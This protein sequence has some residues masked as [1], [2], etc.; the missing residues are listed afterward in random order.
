MIAKIVKGQGFRGV[1]N[2][3][4]D[5]AKGTQLIVA[6]GLRLKDV[7][8]VINSFNRQ[9]E[10]NKRITK[11]VY[12]ISLDFSANDKAK[13]TN[14]LMVRIAQSYM[15]KMGIKDTQYL[16]ARHFDKEHP[17][18]HLII[19]RVNYNGK[20][21]SDKNDRKRSELICKELTRKHQLYFAKGKEQV[22]VHRLRGADKT[23]YEIY[24]ALKVAIP[25]CK[26]WKD[27]ELQLN[28]EGIEI[29][30]KYKGQSDEVQGVTF[31]K[32]GL[33]FRG[34][35]V[36]R[37]YSFSK[38][39]YQIYCNCQEVIHSNKPKLDYK[40]FNALKIGIELL[41]PDYV[42]SQKQKE[43]R[44]LDNQNKYKYKKRRF[45]PKL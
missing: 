22:K 40:T 4:L 23:K 1:V 19:N 28:H 32:D 26:T 33:S 30:Y 44:R 15:E 5:E 24:E 37:Q 17:H 13:L 38:I 41:N 12:H 34:S 11:P 31:S 43:Q 45:G 2:Y 7:E 16:I 29:N 3:V 6:E 27:L 8:S 25:N 14:E 20:T 9:V 18:I 36:D 21:I 39:S 42:H 10:L 35:K